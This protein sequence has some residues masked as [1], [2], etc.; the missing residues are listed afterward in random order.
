LAVNP[1]LTFNDLK[2][3][4]ETTD[5]NLSVHARK[6]ED[7][8]Y[9]VCHKSFDGR[10]PRTSYELTAAGRQALEQYLNQMEGLIAAMRRRSG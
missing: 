4:L 3:L 7:A 6:L 2:A 1:T 5:G 10:Q 9:I 8:G